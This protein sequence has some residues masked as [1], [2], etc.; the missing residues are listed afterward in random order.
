MSMTNEMMEAVEKD[1]VFVAT[2][3]TEGIPNVVPI[4]FARP[5]DENTIL[6]A[7]N[8]MKKTRENLEGNPKISI[9]TK[10]S[11]K[12]PYQFKGSVE[13]FTDGK[14]FETVTEWGQNAMTKLSPKAAILMKVEEV[15]SIQ[16][17]PDAG[18]KID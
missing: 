2:A 15:Y 1:L 8:Y 3:N 5:L 12:C 18:K 14:Y 4:G 16:P 7:D 13:I 11:T 10:D 6:I 17:G 9:V